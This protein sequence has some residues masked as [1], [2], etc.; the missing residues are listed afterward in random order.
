MTTTQKIMDFLNDFCI[1]VEENEPDYYVSLMMDNHHCVE[2][3][4]EQYYVPKSHF[5]YGEE[6]YEIYD[7]LIENYLV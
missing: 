7:Y 6:E 3:M 5:L 1:K 2:L 4:E